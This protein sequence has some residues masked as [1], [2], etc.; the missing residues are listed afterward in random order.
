MTRSSLLTGFVLL[1]SLDFSVYSQTPG[2]LPKP[3]FFP[4]ST[5]GVLPSNSI[6]HLVSINGM[7]WAGTGNGLARSNDGGRSWTGYSANPE[8]ARPGIFSIAVRGD[9]V[10][11]STG[12]SKDVS[13]ASV[14]TG[15]GSTYT[16]DNG[17]TWHGI[18]QPL[19]PLNDSAV[20]Y[21][22]NTIHFL[23][24][25][26]PEQ[27]VTFNSAITDSAVWIAS[28][29][30]GLRKSTDL[31]STWQRIVLPSHNRSSIAP[32]DTLGNYS[33]DP[34]NDNNYL[35]FSVAAVGDD[36]IW[37]GTAGGINRSFDGGRSWLHFTADNEAAHIGSDWVLAIAAQ[38]LGTRT[39]IWATNWPAEGPTQV[40][41]TS[42]TDDG[43]LTWS[44]HLIGTKSYG[45]A[46]KDSIAY[47]AA[48]DGIYRTNDG[49]TTWLKS[50]TIIDPATGNRITSSAF[51]SVA[52]IGDSVFGA[53]DDGL[54]RTIDNAVHPFGTAWEIVRSFV[55]SQTTANVY[56]Y[57]NPFS[58]GFGSA[59]IHYTTGAT[60]GTVTIELFD[61]GMNRL[62]TLLKDASRL[63]ES[64][65]IWD[66]K[67]QWSKTVVNGVYFYR[68]TI[69]N[70]TPAWG[71]I[72]VLQ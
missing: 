42:Y 22:S 23:P 5:V 21:G 7:L 24:I 25:V 61:F 37:T 4:G 26:V 17:I 36:T 39:R 44:N 2:P 34:R 45:F 43:G 49:G 38:R 20:V 27:N 32:T 64:D 69:S 16:I 31:G 6:S 63:G 71:K 3:F 53:S 40:Y 56:A 48:G 41:A 59:R 10:W 65:E 12:Y 68:V 51:F 28:W 55:P 19:D 13:G 70:G 14:Q 54:A 35:A 52:V 50:G 46:F 33:I 9:T 58:P 1:V 47:V 30:S 66:G 8:F 67:D 18:P 62:R 60:P 15:S 57:P 72:L 11:A 29:S